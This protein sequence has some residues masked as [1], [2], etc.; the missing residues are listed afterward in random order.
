MSGKNMRTQNSSKCHSGSLIHGHIRDKMYFNDTYTLKKNMFTKIFKLCLSFEKIKD[1][2][3][4]KHYR[5]K[6]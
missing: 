5:F 4:R 3:F 2:Y 6:K 1:Q